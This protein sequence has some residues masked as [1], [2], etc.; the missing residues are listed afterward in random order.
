VRTFTLAFVVA[1]TSN[2]GAYECGS[3]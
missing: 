1:A 2:T 3:A